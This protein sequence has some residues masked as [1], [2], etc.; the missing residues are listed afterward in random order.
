MCP[1]C[2]SK[3]YDFIKGYKCCD[4]GKPISNRSTRCMN[5]MRISSRRYR[6]DRVCAE[7]GKEYNT[8]PSVKKVFCSK[9]CNMKAQSR[10]MKT[11]RIAY[12]SEETLSAKGYLMK[13][14]DKRTNGKTRNFSH[15]LISGEVIGRNLKSTEIVHHINLDKSDNRNCNLLICSV[16]YHQWIHRQMAIAWAREHLSRK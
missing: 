7:C 15:R 1:N 11:A 3:K 16:S 10:R 12:K 8:K 6:V 5:C 2:R 9:S 4:C 13:P 14:C